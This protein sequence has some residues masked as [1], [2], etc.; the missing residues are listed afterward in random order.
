MEIV[1]DSGQKEMETVV[2]YTDVEKACEAI[3]TV[4]LCELPEETR[5]IEGVDYVLQ[6]CGQILKNK[7]V[8]LQ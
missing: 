7:A 8:I 3:L 2:K 1:Q 6:E 5:T 4:M